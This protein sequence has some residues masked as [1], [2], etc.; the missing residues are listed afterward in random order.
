MVAVI[1]TLLV[2]P[3]AFAADD[4]FFEA[5]WAL[6]QIEAPGAWAASTGA[7]V[8]IG[9]VDTGVDPTHPDLRGKIDAIADCVGRPCVDGA[10]RDGHGHGTLVAGVAAAETDNGR[11]ISGV[12]PGARLVVARAVDDAGRGSVE[13]IS[14]AIRW[15]VDRGARIVNLSLGDP[16]FLLTSLLGTPLRPAI[17][18]VWD[19][20]A[21]PVLASGNENVGL[22]GLGSS[23]YGDL[24]ALIVGASGR[25]GGPAPYS[26]PIGNAKWGVIAPGGDGTGPP[27]DIV[28]TY[29]ASAYAWTA[30]TSMAAPHAA[31]T[32]ALL[33]GQGLSREAAVERLLSTADVVPCGSGCRGRINARRAVGTAPA[34]AAAPAGTAPPPA[35]PPATAPLPTTPPPT[36]TSTAAPTTTAV[37]PTTAG[38]SGAGGG[39]A[40]PAGVAADALGGN[41]LAAAASDGGRSGLHPGLIAAAVTLVAVVALGQATVVIQRVTGVGGW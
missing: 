36:P 18:A 32:L 11:G 40:D 31:G 2:A 3:P 1:L 28:S 23:N 14:N 17:E 37:P 26:S 29:R 21:I 10:G 20:G 13:D 27:N 34:T 8:T 16:N 22:L 12:A 7:G 5:Q 41:D 4:P 38:S 25:S 19:R 24:H 33:L 15:V 39:E 30:G 35:S 9:I 6:A